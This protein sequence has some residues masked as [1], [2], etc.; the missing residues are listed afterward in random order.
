MT[1]KTPKKKSSYHH[2]SLRPALVEASLKLIAKDGVGALT[3]RKVASMADVSHAAPYAHFADKDDLI[4]AIKEEGFRVLRGRVERALAG[5]EPLLPK[6]AEA[7][8]RFALEHT[9][10]FQVMFRNPLPLERHK[11]EYAFLKLG[12][13]I[14]EMMVGVFAKHG[15]PEKARQMALMGW[16]LIHGLVSLRIDGPLMRIM[17]ESDR[18]QRFEALVRDTIA[19]FEKM[20]AI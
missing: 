13:E 12:Q 19:Q 11:P 16:S 15:S 8:V 2:G 9:A 18:P 4:A 14:F 10:M 7:Y 3:L 1:K 5:G 6:L 20:L 17:P